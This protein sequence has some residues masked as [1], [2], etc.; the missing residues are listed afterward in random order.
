MKN[1]IR[2]E[3]KS[4]IIYALKRAFKKSKFWKKRLNDCGIKEQDINEKLDLHK[5]PLLD[6]KTI[7]QDQLE[8]PPY[9]SILSC[10]PSEILRVHKTS[11]TTS[12][13]FLI[14]LTAND[15][16]DTISVA[17]K[18]FLAAGLN[19]KDTIVHCLNFNM[20][21]GG[22]TDYLSLEDTGATSIPFGSGNTFALID[23]IQKLSVNAISCTPS[24]MFKIKEKCEEI[25]LDIKNLGLKKG[26]F[27]GENLLQLSNI[28]SKIE[29]D[30]N[31][32]AID[33]N[34]GLSEV[35][36]IIGGEDQ[37]RN[38]LIYN[39]HGILYAEILDKNLKSLEIKKG[40]VGEFVFSSLRREGQPFFRY[41]TNDVIEV[42]DAYFDEDD[43]IRIRF[44]IKGRSDEM[45]NVKGVN[46]FPESLISILN[47]I[48]PDLSTKYKVKKISYDK[49]ID[50]K[51]EVY[52]EK[53]YG[54][55]NLE[56]Y[57]DIENKFKRLVKQKINISIKLK[58]VEKNYF[59]KQGLNKLN[60]TI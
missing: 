51:P 10:E 44:K 3:E 54:N 9:G 43:L 8:N 45:F 47:E 33:A 35:L 20:W 52:M 39:A 11:G 22:V 49:D 19:N 53:I 55:E 37:Y 12:S 1:L 40:T 5:I 56:R 24:Y 18:T 29:K 60:F 14:F 4:A 6:K 50:F 34:Y 57:K 42:L 32:T 48:E 13:P 41:R 16:K 2:P 28:R 23:M 30:F 27:G 31:L 59:E 46:F 25:G 21:S 36:S 26:F 58:W 7:I 17:T 15:I 38:G